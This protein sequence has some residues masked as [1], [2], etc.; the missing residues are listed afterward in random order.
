MRVTRKDVARRA[1]VSEASVSYVLNKSRGVSPEITK[2]VWDA[3]KELNYTADMVA[4]M[5]EKHL[6]RTLSPKP[7]TLVM[8]REGARTICCLTGV[9]LRTLSARMREDRGFYLRLMQS[10]TERSEVQHVERTGSGD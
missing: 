7:K 2:K 5:Q 8:C 1:G 6:V 10:E 4:R 3:V 9:G